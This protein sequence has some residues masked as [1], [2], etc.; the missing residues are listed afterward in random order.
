MSDRSAS[1]PSIGSPAEE[2]SAPSPKRSC[3]MIRLVCPHCHVAFLR[4][5]P[6]EDGEEVICPACRQPFVPDEE[7][8]VD[9]EDE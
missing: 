8:W 5:M 1:A 4:V 2:A 9:P 3:A 7:E 6:A